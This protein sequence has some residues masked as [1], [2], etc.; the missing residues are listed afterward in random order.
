MKTS[1][2]FVGTVLSL[3]FAAPLSAADAP[4]TA[5]SPPRPQQCMQLFDPVCATVAT[6]VECVAPPWDAATTET[7]YSNGCMA[8]AD[9]AVIR[10]RPGPC[11]DGEANPQRPKTTFGKE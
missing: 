5:C 6:G 10:H 11:P 4:S 2:F 9:P 7:T 1:R 8:C 3:L